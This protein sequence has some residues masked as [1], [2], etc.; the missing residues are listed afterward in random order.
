VGIPTGELFRRASGSSIRR[1]S[2][3]AS[4]SRQ[5]VLSVSLTLV[6]LGQTSAVCLVR[7]ERHREPWPVQ[8]GSRGASIARN[9]AAI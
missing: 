7:R 9:L 6:S 1:V 8:S 3:T 4:P 5:I 2:N